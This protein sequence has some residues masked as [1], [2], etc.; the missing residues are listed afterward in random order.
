MTDITER[1][2]AEQEIRKSKTRLQLQIDR[3]PIGCIVWSREF[4]VMSWNPAA[5]RIFGFTAEEA[6]GR[7][8]YDFIV[9][10]DTKA[11]VD[12]IFS[13]LLSGDAT[14]H[15][16]N[17]NLTKDG[18][19]IT[20]Q[21]T[22]TPLKE[23]DGTVMGVLAM[24]EDIT[25][26]K[27]AEEQ[28]RRA[29]LYARS[30]I[31]ASLDPL[32][33]ISSEGKIT[34]VNRATELVTGITRARLIGSD[35]C[36]YFTEPD[37]AREGYRKVFEEELVR[38]Y[39]LAIRHV[40]GHITHVLY[41]ASVFRNEAGEVEG[42]FAAAR[43]ISE[44]KVL[45]EQLL[46]AQKLEAIGRLAGGVAH[47]FNNIIGIIL[48]YS[49]LIQGKLKPDDPSA[50]H[51]ESIL[52]AAERAAA[53]TRQLL[54]FSRKQVM[55][56][57]LLDL[58][59]RITEL[60]KML[61]R[62]IGENVEVVLQLTPDLG[63]V[64][65]DPVQFEQVLINLAVNAKDAMPRG[66]RLRIASANARLDSNYQRLHPEVLPGAYVMISVS[67][68]GVG[69]DEST[70]SRIFEPFFTTKAI[71]K[72]TGLGLSIIYGIV[73]QSGGHIWVYSEPGQGTT[74]KIYLPRVFAPE[75]KAALQAPPTPVTE[76]ASGTILVVED[77]KAL[78]EM[79]RD[80]LRD[81]GYTVLLA[82]NGEEAMRVARS[83]AG[84]IDLL[85]T[86]VVLS[87]GINGVGLAAHLRALRPEMKV[88][89]MSGYSDVLVK[90]EADVGFGAVLLEKPFNVDVLRAT[91]SKEL[92][93]TASILTSAKR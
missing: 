31:E 25:E 60:S 77:E 35:F 9:P 65:A 29:S 50:K 62:L 37:K 53:L 87:A 26:R 91:V 74:F 63:R 39:P 22:N 17:E 69:M 42:A 85:L 67:D 24:V 78:A 2:R 30:L 44:R 12:G 40:S 48:G 57:R 80:A 59:E 82:G 51:L 72:G 6:L 73:R 1:K 27:Q 10:A 90:A 8:P 79:T 83:H 70:R 11:H 36:D 13:R 20:C 66:G 43:D 89:Y 19:T 4:R 55:D 81:S 64:K 16:T 5:E 86:D 14:A 46:Q 38:D 21:W 49:A 3:M 32:V 88:I 18:R 34:D 61:P 7:H 45:E 52:R 92:R 71:G 15:S 93:R 33:T 47:D 68:T 56:V 28:L 41:N 54:A 75:E 76:A 58:N 23:P 84:P